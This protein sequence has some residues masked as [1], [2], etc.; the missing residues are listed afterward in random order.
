MN[1][2]RQQANVHRGG[3]GAFKTLTSVMLNSRLFW[4]GLALLIIL[5]VNL[6]ISP[7][8]FEIRMVNDR[9]IGSIINILDNSAPYI[10]LAIG[11]TLVIA[12]KGIDL[13]VGAVM[14]I[15]A[16]VAVTLIK[17]Y[18]AGSTEFYVQPGFVILITIGV[19]AI[20]GLW[21]GIL[22]AFLNLQP[23]IATLILMVAG[24]GVAQLITNGQSPTF[25]NDTLAFVGRG[26]VWGVPFPIYI[27]F[28]ALI[29]ITLLVRRTALGLLIESVGVNDRASYYAGIQAN[30]I[31]VFVY[32]LSGVCAAIAGMIVAGEVKSADPHKAGL[33]SE[34]DAILAVVIGGTSLLGG[35]FYLTLSVMGVLIIQ[36]MLVGLYVSTLHPTTNLVV[37]AVVVLAVLLLQSPEFR[38]FITQPFRRLR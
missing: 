31:K 11:M 25:T 24:R 22:I 7:N 28:I 23:I 10:L 20:C 2:E 15:C 21:N 30:T 17:Q 8:F 3:R 6:Q 12:T 36:S 5:L 16:A 34:L 35:R 18:E 37:K 19:G 33:F 29:L 9:L 38:R 27:A 13:S 14:A 1:L 26:V 32:V 4:T